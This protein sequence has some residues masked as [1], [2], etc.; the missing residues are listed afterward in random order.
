MAGTPPS[1]TQR[2]S[3]L[4]NGIGARVVGVLVA[5]DLH[6]AP[7]RG[8]D[9]GE[10]PPGTAPVVHAG[11]LQMRDLDVDA[12]GLADRDRL[13]HRL[14]DLVGLVADVRGVGASVLA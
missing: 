11:Q 13:A 7:A 6:A 3:R 10:E 9:L 5:V 8:V 12:R 14:E 1:W 4:R 2:G